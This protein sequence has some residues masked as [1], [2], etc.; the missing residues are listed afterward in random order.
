LIGLLCQKDG[1]AVISQS[2]DSQEGSQKETHDDRQ[3]PV[4]VF[5]SALLFSGAEFQPRKQ[6]SSERNCKG[7]RHSLTEWAAAL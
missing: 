1:K 6:D 7:Q 5:S 4:A 3:F 2:P